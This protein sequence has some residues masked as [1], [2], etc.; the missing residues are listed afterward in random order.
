MSEYTVLDLQGDHYTMGRQH[1]L[2]VTA[3]RPLIAEAIEAVFE[4]LDQHNPGARFEALLRETRQVLQ[5]VDA[6]LLDMIRGG[7]FQPDERV[8]FWHTGGTAVLFGCAP[9]A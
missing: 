9:P 2:Q 3:L 6:P 5:E 7:A 1:G 4:Q 8:L